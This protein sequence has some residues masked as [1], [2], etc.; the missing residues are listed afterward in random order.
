MG[1][2]KDCICIEAT[3]HGYASSHESDGPTLEPNVNAILE[4]GDYPQE[5]PRNDKFDALDKLRVDT[6]GKSNENCITYNDKQNNTN[7]HR[8]IT[9]LKD[10]PGV[11]C[12]SNARIPSG[13]TKVEFVPN[14]NDSIWDDDVYIE[15]DAQNKF[16]QPFAPRAGTNV[17]V[18]KAAMGM[19]KTTQLNNFIEKHAEASFLVISSRITLSYTQLGV[20]S[21]FQ[22][23]SSRDW[24]GR[25]LIVQYES[26]HKITKCYDYIVLDEV[27]SIISCITSV[28][29]NGVHLRT[30]ALIIRTL[31]KEA[32]L[33]IAL[34]ADIEIDG[35]VPF[36]LSSV[37][38]NDS[39]HLVRYI[40]TKIRRS[41]LITKDE[42]SYVRE[43][44]EALASGKK[45]CIGCQSKKRA[46]MWN[47]MFEN[48]YNGKIYTSDTADKEIQ[49]LMNIN[50]AFEKSQYVILTSKVTWGCDHTNN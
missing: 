4:A 32:K 10:K 29:T 12:R 50:K 5:V 15:I 35:A 41:L 16:V 9:N 13:Y 23:Y 2:S 37:V 18:V 47:K 42:K 45:I 6:L 20:L 39:V 36:F 24:K 31:I 43:I 48:E 3:H 14:A 38:R 30:N 28:K 21:N 27:R 8:C 1:N 11:L 7:I 40:K 19:G 22:H 17:Y 44:N 49:E 46:L 34:D 33:T 26:L 25:R